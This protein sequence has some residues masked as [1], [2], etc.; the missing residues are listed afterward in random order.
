MGTVNS[1]DLAINQWGQTT[2]EGKA[3]FSD[4]NNERYLND[5]GARQELYQ[6][7][8]STGKLDPSYGSDFNSQVQSSADQGGTGLFSP[9]G[10]GTIFS[11]FA[12]AAG[13][14][15]LASGAFA[16]SGLPGTGGLSF[17]N[18]P[19][20]VAPGSSIGAVD[21]GLGA[22][23]PA[24]LEIANDA[25]LGRNALSASGQTY[26]QFLQS[27]TSAGVPAA[28]AATAA[29]AA[30]GG[31]PMD[32]ALKLA[33]VAAPVVAALISSGAI[34]SASQGQQDAAQQ[35]IAG[36]TGATSNAQNVIQ[37]GLQQGIDF[38]QKQYDAGVAKQDEYLGKT[39]A[40]FQPYITAG[41][42][43]INTLADRLGTSGN[44]TAA[45]YGDLTKKFTLADFWD[46]P[47][48]KASFQTGLDTG[49][50]ALN[51]AAAR[52]GSLNSGGQAKA[53]DRF[54]TDYT[55]TQAGASHDR[56]VGDQ[57]SI[58]NK[59]FGVSQLGEQ[60]TNQLG[61]YRQ[62]TANNVANSGNLLATN[63]AQ[64]RANAATNTANIGI[65]SA[66]SIANLVT[67]AANA[68]GAAS[69]ATGNAFQ[70]AGNSVA[71]WFQSQD[72]LDRI[73]GAK[74]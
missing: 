45:N 8:L 56:F 29:K 40:D 36:I 13:A 70:N 61:G 35:S 62:S 33:G 74:K 4:P 52:A 27:L 23:N 7:L 49:T 34:K 14:A 73:L 71:N 50:K 48:T 51:N 22:Y 6:Y 43:A 59:I 67:G 68:R 15:G 37:S 9:D 12:L 60:A 46:D 28:A 53:L 19:G 17:G 25:E 21:A 38:G 47:V 42:G 31:T 64:L 54:A 44:T 63:D 57:N 39:T 16:G 32:Q 24:A 5:P 65:G 20:I 18:A 26:P 72:T 11:K 69:I 41:A 58:Y 66:N 1:G 30:A 2:P 55:G 3:F 10:L